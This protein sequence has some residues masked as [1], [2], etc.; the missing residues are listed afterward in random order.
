MKTKLMQSLAILIAGLLAVV[1][2]GCASTVLPHS[3]SLRASSNVANTQFRVN[4]KPPAQNAASSTD[5]VFE[6]SK[7]TKGPIDVTAITPDGQVQH[8][9]VT[10]QVKDGKWF[11]AGGAVGWTVVTGIGGFADIGIDYYFKAYRDLSCNVVNFAFAAPVAYTYQP[12][13]QPAPAPPTPVAPP[14]PAPIVIN[15]IM[16]DPAPTPTPAPVPTYTPPPAKK[17]PG[18]SNTTNPR[19]LPGGFRN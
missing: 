16:P 2:T 12:P 17:L 1:V 8:K 13:P 10:W 19:Q 3:A 11:L 15:N 7:R 6:I 4:D 5:A 14:T 18:C 9:F